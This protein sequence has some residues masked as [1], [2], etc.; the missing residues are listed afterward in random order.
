MFILA[1][2]HIPAVTINIFGRSMHYASNNALARTTLGNL[3]AQNVTK[4]AIPGCDTKSY[5]FSGACAFGKSLFTNLSSYR[6]F[7]SLIMTVV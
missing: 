7:L 2:L 4:V 6:N 3:G 5:N 1:I